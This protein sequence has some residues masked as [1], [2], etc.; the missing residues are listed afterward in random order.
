MAAAAV[1]LQLGV[2]APA[3]AASGDLHLAST[4]DAG[5]KANRDSDVRGVSADGTRVLF[6]TKATNL[7]A[8]DTDDLE[9]VYVKDLATGALILASTSDTGTK[10]N[11]DSYEASL[12]AD[13]TA[14]AFHTYAT[15][16]DAG[17]TDEFQD[18]YV[19]DL[20][21]GALILPP[22]PT[23]APRPTAAASSR[24]CRRTA[25]GSPS[26]PGPPTSARATPTS[27]WTSTSRTSPP[28]P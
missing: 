5:V 16:L 13:G 17:D 20:T 23:P 1:A 28:A 10:A 15:N 22:P 19:K 12:S 6:S 4:T 25:P 24:A 8:R 26:D 7:D 2:S 18:I 27:T 3:L 11:R 14:V 21:T 9:D